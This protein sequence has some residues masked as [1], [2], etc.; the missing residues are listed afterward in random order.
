M[1]IKGKNQRA[2]RAPALRLEFAHCFLSGRGFVQS[3]WTLNVITEC[4][5]L[6]HAAGALN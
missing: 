3:V 6:D 2:A 5:I 1:R 4:D